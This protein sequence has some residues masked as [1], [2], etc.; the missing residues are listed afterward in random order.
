MLC[1][2]QS[3]SITGTSPSDCFASLEGLTPLQRCNWCILQSQLTGQWDF[4]DARVGVF[5]TTLTGWMQILVAIY[6]PSTEPSVKRCTCV[7]KR[8]NSG[9]RWALN[10]NITRAQTVWESWRQDAELRASG[11]QRALGPQWPTV[12]QP[13][14]DEYYC[15]AVLLGQYSSLSPS[16]FISHTRN[17]TLSRMK[18][19]RLYF[20]KEA[21]SFVHCSRHYCWL[22][23]RIYLY[24][25]LYNMVRIVPVVRVPIPQTVIKADWVPRIISMNGRNPS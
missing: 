7:N 14:Q 8:E 16:Q 25:W 1:I 4:G 21:C 13:S 11:R 2:L 9:S 15:T 17:I 5:K 3:S 10:N 6:W 12:E 22:W 23:F 24:M 18:C 19:G 20:Y